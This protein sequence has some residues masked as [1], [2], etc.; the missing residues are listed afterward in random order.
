M[1]TSPENGVTEGVGAAVDVDD[2]L[3]AGDEE[4]DADGLGVSVDTAPP[5]GVAQPAR[6]RIAAMPTGTA[7]RRLL[8]AEGDVRGWFT[9]ITPSLCG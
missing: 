4:T 3:G 2:A 8:F 5:T 1:R 7:Q 6:A 9:G